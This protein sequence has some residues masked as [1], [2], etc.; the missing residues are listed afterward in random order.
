MATNPS[1]IQKL[2]TWGKKV[3]GQIADELANLLGGATAQKVEAATVALFKSVLMP[4]A[5]SALN[6]ARDAVTG[7]V[8]ATTAVA[9][10]QKSAAAA[11][12]QLTQSA[13]LQLIAAASSAIS[14]PSAPQ[15]TPTPLPGAAQ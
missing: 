9:T 13:A 11:G 3:D 5:V 15:P 8:D 4:L 12:K 7:Q 14:N 6:E 2:I 1:E 10:L